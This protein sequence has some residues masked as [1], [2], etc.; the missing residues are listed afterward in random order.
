MVDASHSTKPSTGLDALLH[1]VAAKVRQAGVF[2]EVTV[3]GQRVEAAA[4]GSAAPAHYRV[5]PE[6]G[7]LW[8]SLVM[9]DRWLSH[10]IEADLLH[11][12]DDLEDLIAE[13][14]IELGETNPPRPPCEHF[15]SEDKLFTFRSCLGLRPDDTG[16]AEKAATWLL[17]Y[18]ACFR[19]LGEMTE[20]ED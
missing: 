18:E 5:E 6:D 7:V 1:T 2:G 17:A 16:A 10:S 3:S 4:K 19:A 20:A 8:V 12:G 9:A 14:L 13:E 15:R 11:T